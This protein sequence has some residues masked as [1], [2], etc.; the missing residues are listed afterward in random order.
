MHPK[1]YPCS[2]IT[3]LLTQSVFLLVSILVNTEEREAVLHI[4]AAGERAKK[5][6]NITTE[7]RIAPFYSFCF[8]GISPKP[9]GWV[10]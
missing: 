8:E 1:S 7:K 2:Q 9:E 10:A 6:V 4:R 5:D 3:P